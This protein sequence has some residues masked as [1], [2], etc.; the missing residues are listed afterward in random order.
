MKK[1]RIRA[2]IHSSHLATHNQL[3]VEMK[4]ARIRALILKGFFI[5]F[6]I[7]PEVEMKKA[8]IRALIHTTNNFP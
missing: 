1:A 7:L 4:K 5:L 6:M 2:L 3:S 8:R